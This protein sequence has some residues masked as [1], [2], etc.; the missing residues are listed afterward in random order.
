MLSI[1]KYLFEDEEE[2]KKEALPEEKL[3]KSNRRKTLAIA[4]LLGVTG[5][6]GLSQLIQNLKK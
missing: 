5:G 6:M 1:I 2:L 3:L 4:G